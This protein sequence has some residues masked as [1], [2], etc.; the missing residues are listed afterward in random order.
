MSGMMLT[1]TL[2]V[3]RAPL[4]PAAAALLLPRP[5]LL[6]RGIMLLV[7]VGWL[8]LPAF[9]RRLGACLDG[10]AA[11]AA[12]LPAC[13]TSSSAA[14]AQIKPNLRDVANVHRYCLAALVLCLRS[15]GSWQQRVCMWRKTCRFSWYRNKTRPQALL[16]TTHTKAAECTCLQH[17]AEGLTCSARCCSAGFHTLH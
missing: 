6:L 7:L 1:T 10:V 5:V 13:S 14:Q 15:K 17:V 16:M 8:L 3:S 9:A 12:F 2:L 11:P 4:P